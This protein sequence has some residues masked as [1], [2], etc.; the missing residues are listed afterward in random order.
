MTGSPS[1]IQSTDDLLE[2]LGRRPT[3]QTWPEVENA[4]R[5]AADE[6]TPPDEALRI[7]EALLRA[8]GAAGED[9]DWLGRV[10][11]EGLV[12]IAERCE[13]RLAGDETDDPARRL[14]WE[15]L[16]VLR[17]TAVLRRIARDDVE[18]WAARILRLLELSHFTVGPLFHQRAEL[19]GSKIL[20]EV[21]PKDPR[22]SWSWR[23]VAARVEFLSRVLLSL[24][25]TDTP[26]PIAILSEN[27]IEMALLDL[28]CLT[29]GLT[30][31]MVPANASETD[32]GYILEH[33]RSGTVIVSGSHQLA[34][35]LKH[36]ES[37]K[38]LKTI[39]TLDAA[40]AG[41]AGVVSLD[42]LA[43]RAESVPRVAPHQRSERVRLDD[44]ATVMYTSGTTG[45]PKAIPFSHRNI[46]FKRFARALA[47]PEIGDEDV[48][49]CF[50]PLFHTFGRYLEL[51]NCVFLG[52]T[53]CFLE[54]TSPGGLVRGMRRYRPTVFISVPK[55]WIQLHEL[56]AQKADPVEATDEE[57]L[58]A[59]R[60]TTGGR[61]RWGLSAAGHLDS[62]IFRAF[63]HQGVE[64]L[65]GFG[66][67][68][69]TGGITMTPPGEYEE[70]SLGV[71]LPGIELRLADDGELLV[72][73]AYVMESYLDSPAGEPAF[74]EDG[75]LHT[76]DLMETTAGGH[77]RLVDRKK[78]IYKNIKGE[79]IAPQRVEN[80][81]REFESVGRAFLV[82]DHRDYNT[83][84]IYPHPGYT[85]L[86]LQ[87]LS[88]QEVY[89]HFRSLVVSVNQFL[90][91]YERVVDF[92]VIP[93]DLE[94]AR[95]ELTPKGT[96]RR[97]TVERNFSD[98]VSGLYR[99]ASLRVGDLDLVIP[100]WLLQ[101]LGLTTRDI[102]SGDGEII[103]PTSGTRLT[104]RAS[105]PDLAQ[106]GSCTYRH[107][108]GPLDL[109]VL[110]TA[111]RLWL[112]NE[113]L[114]SFVALDM[115]T[116]QRSSQRQ[117]RI[118]WIDRPAPY[119][120]GKKDHQTLESFLGRDDLDPLDLE[121]AARMLASDNE[122]DA[123]LAI[124]V[125]EEILEYQA[126]PMAELS[127]L[128]LART[129]GEERGCV[130]RRG[131]QVLA[132]AEKES[133]FA[134]VLARFLE[135][136][137]Q[138]LDAETRVV[139][140]EQI[141]T[142]DKLETFI[143]RAHA[144]CTNDA[145]DRQGE[146]PACGLLRFLAA[147]GAVHP[148]GYRRIR[149]FLERM[150][151]FARHESLRGEA[152]RAAGE[153]LAGF[154]DWLGRT[155]QIAVDP[156]R[157]KEYRWED[158]VV[159]DDAV[160]AADRKRLLRAM[161]RTSFLRE[162]VFLFSAGV[163][164]R[165]SDIVTR[166]LRVRL[167][168]RL[169]GKSVYRISVQTRFQGSFDVAVNVNHDLPSE[170]IQEEIQWLVL[171]G[172]PSYGREPLVEEFGGY[173]SEQDLWSE[174]FIVGDTLHRSMRR[175]AQLPDHEERLGRLWPFMAWATLAAYVDF[176]YR[177]G[178][179]LE[180]ADPDMTNIIV[181]MQ[182]FISGVRIVSVSRRRPHI[183]LLPMLRAFRDEFVAQAEEQYPFL[184]GLVG[185]PVVFSS[186]LEVVG[187]DKG[188]ALLEEALAEADG[189]EADEL[190]TELRAYLTN[191][192]ERGFM[193]L[194]LYFATER[195]RRWSNLTADATAKA[196]A[197]TLRELYD[198]YGLRRLA[199]S[200]PEIRVRFYRETVFRD[201][202]P[203]LDEGLMR[204][205]RAIRNGELSPEDLR[206][207]VD[208]IRAQPD[209]GPDDEYFL[210][211]LSYPYLLPEDEA[212]FVQ[213]DL[214][215]RRKS[216]IV[217]TL[218]DAEGSVFRVRHA[219]NPK[220]V[221]RLL[222]LFLA[223]KL[224]VR[225]RMEHQYLVAINER[226]SAASI[227]KSRRK[228][229][230]LTWK[231]SSSPSAIKASVWLTG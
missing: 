98:V 79:T 88:E 40:A 156:D 157:G 1:Q 38:R 8:L 89:D 144:A 185:W 47:L 20:F 62:D 27:R 160:P 17:R 41:N 231:R 167:L 137:P 10:P 203:A 21:D 111:P 37:L 198:T 195:Y 9:Q 218:E 135:R 229:A 29:A 177:S 107:P 101:L 58:A 128:L 207:A 145:A 70:G 202:A 140:A 43:P 179:R 186:V 147:Y 129:A 96:P 119:A 34:K 210:A 7:D 35:V 161:K 130:R 66:M 120:P 158:V 65:S 4:L 93:R 124:R 90:A 76:G 54:N 125:L 168:G 94:E 217:V 33:S 123:L 118:D 187:E 6:A 133:R 30:N 199:K 95:D 154:R 115:V 77:L 68:E 208:E 165:L 16:D 83:L 44:M 224:D 15:L 23:R 146:E 64:L 49:L 126:E 204:V 164:I 159:F 121:L 143:D 24:D 109:G 18:G 194:R 122:V 14:T 230:R 206:D 61:L 214:G 148:T 166:G 39:V 139:L 86:D 114:V 57:L 87:A 213:A 127:R 28:A 106:I 103:L 132:P 45:T 223:A 104:V 163:S 2:R 192:S 173:W 219:L 67:T 13:T 196:R 22:G 91:P 110:L 53:Y 226:S 19:Y 80:M 175:L 131:F 171:S 151:L 197:L 46:V 82:G 184:A 75:W 71:A 227:T 100:N 5:R 155:A 178:K 99:R 55:K 51:M 56:I 169:H 97:K 52:A 220:E 42:S 188:L 205:I 222:R 190:R 3:A 170:Q 73:G 102:R 191:V 117:E 180:I 215:G 48:F 85:E 200:Y 211:R 81:F 74:D 221:E 92:A 138:L 72:R 59:T 25:P 84:L 201:C 36:R 60:H 176:W 32:V 69:A 152:R 113:E 172:D 12:A 209:L 31:V 63:Q 11:V 150:N 149:A 136:D 228:A 181:P 183:G 141:L 105:G 162:A 134:D 142:D 193:P 153:L 112:G 174:E 212:G 78:E 108:P 216:D 225:F 116:R 189:S 182:D 50:L 26:A